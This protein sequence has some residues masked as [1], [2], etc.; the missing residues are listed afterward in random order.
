MNLDNEELQA[1]ETDENLQ[2][3]NLE[4]GSG[5]ENSELAPENQDENSEE[6]QEEQPAKVV[7][8][9]AQQGVFDKAMDKKTFERREAERNSERLE[10]ENEELRSKIPVE[11]RPTVP[12]LPD[13]YSDTYE[14]D[15]Q[16]YTK[17]VQDAT[18]F[19][20]RE[21]ETK[22]NQEHDQQQQQTKQVQQLQKVVGDYTTRAK[23]MN[24]S[25]AD[26]KT[27]SDAVNAHGISNDLTMHI[28]MDEKGP[29]ITK[30]L[31]GNLQA[32]DDM[33]GMTPMQMAVYV[34]TKI[35]PA[36]SSKKTS[37]APNPATTLGDGGGAPPGDR[38]PKGAT[39]T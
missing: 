22:R 23:S 18:T 8:D 32:L 27:A 24:I 13:P 35:K 17:A 36:L 1:S 21:A 31:A 25:D 28:L 26:L 4:A 2:E 12:K 29:A 9:E 39:F 3:E 19:D 15:M 6:N 10:L 38:G 14:Q 11:T 37:S 34:E 33:R 16:D 5:D 30:H 20:S 7:F